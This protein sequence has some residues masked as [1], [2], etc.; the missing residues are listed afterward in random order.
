MPAKHHLSAS[1]WEQFF[2]GALD[3]RYVRT[4]VRHLLARCPICSPLAAGAAEGSELGDPGLVTPAARERHDTVGRLLRLAQE[5]RRGREAWDCLQRMPPAERLEQVESNPELATAALCERLIEEC[6][7]ACWSQ[8]RAAIGLARLALA[9]ALR[10][11]CA[12]TSPGLLADLRGRAL[13]CLADARRVTG[14]L[15]GAW[16]ALARCEEELENGTGD[17]REAAILERSTGELLAEIWR[18]DDACKSFG[19]AAEIYAA[20]EDP[21]LHG[22]ALTQL[23]MAV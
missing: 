6:G 19:L 13:A 17:P 20:L 1:Q 7:A 8:P 10:V 3:H 15:E 14:D 16:E 21:D 11:R 23:A 22:Q 18:L 2:D 5:R 12:G 4:G 9:V